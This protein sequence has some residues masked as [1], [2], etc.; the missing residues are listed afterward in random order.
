M[1]VN[2]FEEGPGIYLVLSLLFVCFSN[3]SISIFNLI[4][5]MGK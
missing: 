5:W 3:I 2:S 4:F 1:L